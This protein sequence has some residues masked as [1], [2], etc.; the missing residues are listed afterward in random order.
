VKESSQPNGVKPKLME[1]E[2]GNGVNWKRALKQ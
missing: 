1:R 2:L